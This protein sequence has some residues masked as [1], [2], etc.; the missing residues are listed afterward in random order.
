[1]GGSLQASK[2]EAR[3]VLGSLAR[4]S[5]MQGGVPVLSL[6]FGCS[7]SQFSPWGS[8][9]HTQ[10]PISSQVVSVVT[11]APRLLVHTEWWL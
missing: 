10:S 6:V 11:Q 1:M 2:Q 4:L 8:L 3:C 5:L 9:P 7:A